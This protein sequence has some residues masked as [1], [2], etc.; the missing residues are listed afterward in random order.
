M[1]IFILLLLVIFN[2]PDLNAQQDSFSKYPIPGYS[3][4]NNDYARVFSREEINSLDSLI[5][6]YEKQTSVEIGI[7]TTNL[8][9]SD[10][11]DLELFSLAVFNK[12]GIGKKGKNNGILFCISIESRRIWIR[13]GDGITR[14]LSDLETKMIIDSVI[15]PAF[16]KA[17][18]FSGVQNAIVVIEERLSKNGFTGN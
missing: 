17:E 14:F 3:G 8:D 12:W 1:K 9:V 18:Y 5:A 2:I 10:T 15:I 6:A 4:W 16:K 11:T 7:L 13:N